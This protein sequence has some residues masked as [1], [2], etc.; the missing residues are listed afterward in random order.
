MATRE[1]SRARSVTRDEDS[2]F[3]TLVDAPQEH[4]LFQALRV[5]EAHFSDRP[6]L[7]ESRRPRQDAL[8]LGQ[9]A[10]L[11][12]PRQRSRTSSQ[13]APPDRRG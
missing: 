10:E 12:F 2:L 11:A 1:R 6:R 7:G 8:R 4:H 3:D 9:E 5:L 13:V